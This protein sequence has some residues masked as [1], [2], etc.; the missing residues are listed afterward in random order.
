MF[1]SYFPTNKNKWHYKSRLNSRVFDCSV[2]YS[3]KEALDISNPYWI[4]WMCSGSAEILPIKKEPRDDSGRV[5][6]WRKK[7]REGTLPPVLLWYLNCLDAYIIVDGHSRLLASKL[8]NIV[9]EI[10]VAYSS[11]E[12]K[13]EIPESKKSGVLK[14][15]KNR[16]NR[17][18][19]STEE[20]NEVLLE[21]FENRPMS[22]PRTFSTAVPDF[23]K[24]WEN[25]V[26]DF[27][28]GLQVDESL[29]CMIK[30]EAKLTVLVGDE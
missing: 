18:P 19:L 13:Y 16:K 4:N 21:T 2:V 23:N 14:S 15:L 11:V 24:V 1:S 3:G 26:T 27:C 10:I 9:P 5:K 29:R 25:E 17:R 28:S 8:E 20:I 7:A 22:N 6:W 12:F 30:R